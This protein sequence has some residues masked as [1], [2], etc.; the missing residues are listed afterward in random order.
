MGRNVKPGITFYRMDSGHI[1][2]KKVRLLVNEFD[3]DGYYIWSCIVDYSYMNDGYFFNYGNKEEFELFAT[4]FCKKKIPLVKEVIT[5]CLRRG[6]FDSNVAELFGVLTSAMM[7]EVYVYGTAERRRQGS[8]FSMQKEWLLIDFKD[9]IPVNID[10]L[11]VKNII[12]SREESTDKTRQDLDKTKQ[13]NSTGTVVPATDCKTLFKDLEKTK[14]VLCEFIHT[15][16]PDFIEPYV[17]LWNLFANEKKLAQVS[18]I[19]D[20]RKRKFNVRIKEP[21]FNFLDIL[22]KAGQSEFILTSKWFGFDWIMENQS[23]YLKTIEGNYDNKTSPA[24]TTGVVAPIVNLNKTKTEINY[25]YERF[26]ED[27]VS[28][29]GIDGLYYDYL[30]KSGLIDFDAE[31]VEKIKST[32]T[33]DLLEKSIDVT[34]YTLQLRMKKIGVLEFFKQCK[35]KQLEVV[36]EIKN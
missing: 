29:I 34:D 20:S 23:N 35:D 14:K 9:Q 3:S 22:K 16:K 27:K 4:D 5:G 25:L 26:L 11:P 36:F 1:L 7:Q 18:K 13:D 10:I 24:L 30:K 12:T 15:K 17:E 19:S 28:I 21:A 2:N 8:V 31:I 33:R 32:A 6:L